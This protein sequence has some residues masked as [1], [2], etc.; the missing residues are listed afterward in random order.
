MYKMK[1]RPPK[2]IKGR[3]RDLSMVRSF[4]FVSSAYLLQLL[5]TQYQFA[6]IRSLPTS[7]LKKN[8]CGLSSKVGCYCQR[9]LIARY[10][11]TKYEFTAAKSIL[12][13]D[14]SAL[15]FFLKR[16]SLFGLNPHSSKALLSSA[17]PSPAA[18]SKVFV[19][20]K[21]R[22]MLCKDLEAAV[23]WAGIELTW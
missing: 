2:K 21:G 12:W 11:T 1:K 13:K 19:T 22:R 9:S 10:S 8:L 14:G 3:K 5:V 6:T 15:K 7:D 18:Q 20:L 17:W 4:H 23:D 16:V